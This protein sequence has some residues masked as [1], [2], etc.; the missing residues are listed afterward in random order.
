MSDDR[1]V[2][3]LTSAVATLRRELDDLKT[4]ALARA[5][6]RATGDVEATIRSTAKAET[7]LLQGQTLNRADFPVLFQWATDQG[8]I[9]VAGL[10]G[11]GNGTTTFV[12]PD[13]RGRVLLGAG[14]LG[15]D[16]YALGALVGA[17]HPVIVAANLPTHD[18]G[19]TISGHASH[20]HSDSG[21]TNSVGNHGG[22]SSGDA[23]AFAGG[24]GT[25]PTF[26]NAANGGHNHTVDTGFPT[27]IPAH[28]VDVA[29]F[30]SA[31]PTGVDVRQPGIA[32]NWLI[33]V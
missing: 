25:L 23:P 26:Y 28:T 6:R 8:L 9:G 33:W 15:T 4:T 21:F 17:A 24:S 30:G 22:H 2:E 31:S 14:T 3:D 7:L 13:M 5:G 11:A 18:H 27:T 12:L 19:V 29:P 16:T 10:F 32:V 20:G 1:P